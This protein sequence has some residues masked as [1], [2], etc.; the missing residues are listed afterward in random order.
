MLFL[1]VYCVAI[2]VPLCIVQWRQSNHWIYKPI[3]NLTLNMNL[4]WS[5]SIWNGSKF[6]LSAISSTICIP[7][8]FIYIQPRGRTAHHS[9]FFSSDALSDGLYL[10]TEK[11]FSITPGLLWDV[12]AAGEMTFI[13]NCNMNAFF[14]FDLFMVYIPE[15][16]QQLRTM[17]L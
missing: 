8:V 4:M 11:L 3:K 16:K 9:W 2:F 13:L 1:H 17:K 5:L 10:K 6:F 7:Q 15:C 12:F 14:S